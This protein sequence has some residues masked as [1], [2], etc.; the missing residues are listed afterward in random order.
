MPL[1]AA[2][3]ALLLNETWAGGAQVVAARVAGAWNFSGGYPFFSGADRAAFF[4]GAADGDALSGAL[5]ALA[6]PWAA[7][8]AVAA[9]HTGADAWAPAWAAGAPARAATVRTRWRPLRGSS[10]LAL[11]WTSAASH[12]RVRG[13]AAVPAGAPDGSDVASSLVIEAVAPFALP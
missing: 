9:L 8:P 2:C 11:G 10:G 1:G 7:A 5:L 4:S 12:V 3:T 6:D 13:T